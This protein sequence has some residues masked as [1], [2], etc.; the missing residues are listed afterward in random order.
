MRLNCQLINKNNFVVRLDYSPDPV[1]GE[2]FRAVVNS[3]STKETID[4]LVGAIEEHL[5]I[6]N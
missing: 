1:Y 5:V 4:A 3:R 6:L 2:F